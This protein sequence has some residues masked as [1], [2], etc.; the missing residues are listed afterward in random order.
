MTLSVI[1]TLGCQVAENA[2]PLTQAESSEIGS[3]VGSMAEELL[4]PAVTVLAL[5]VEAGEALEQEIVK[6]LSA[7]GF[8]LGEFGR[9]V[10]VSLTVEGDLIV[11][12]LRVGRNRASTAIRRTGDP[13]WT[14]PVMVC[15]DCPGEGGD[16]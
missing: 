9:K 10:K 4:P 7:V 3:T 14:A 6:S 8:G 13:S 5:E 16:E 11:V 2:M 12:A 1:G 15:T